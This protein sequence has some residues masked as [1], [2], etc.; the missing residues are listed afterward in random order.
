ME[1]EVQGEKNS[2]L[3]L[4]RRRTSRAR[5]KEKQFTCCKGKRKWKGK[6]KLFNMI[7]AR[8]FKHYSEVI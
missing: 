2:S 7:F 1:K 6:N 4:Q 8:M 3:P 5:K